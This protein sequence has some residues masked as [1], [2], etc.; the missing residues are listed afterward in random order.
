MRSKPAVIRYDEGP[1]AEGMAFDLRIR[2]LADGGSVTSGG[3][4]LVVA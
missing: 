4:T 1:D 2:I 3:S